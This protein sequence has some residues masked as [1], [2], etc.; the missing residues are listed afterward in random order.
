MQ[1]H[2]AQNIIEIYQKH[3]KAWTELRGEY[4][5]EK[6]WLDH[7]LKLVKKPANVLD[8][9]CGS[10][11]TIARYLIENKCNYTGV[12]TSEQMLDIAKTSFPKQTWLQLDMRYVDLGRTF[13]GILAWDS[14]FHLHPSDQRQ[15]FEVFSKHAISGA[16]LMFTSGSQEGEAI[17]NLFGDDLYHASLAPEEYRSL[18]NQYGFTVIAMI[19]EDSECTGHT[20]W[21][22]QKN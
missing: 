4:L 9:G 11:Q 10:A 21:L 5:Y 18:L 17:G 7:F 8:L 14:F 3:G 19:P 12:D 2:L 15:M 20:I 6:K 13:Q 1:K 16:S 22:A